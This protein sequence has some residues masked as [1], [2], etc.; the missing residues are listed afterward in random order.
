MNI[1][2]FSTYA[3]AVLIA[4]IAAFSFFAAMTV[5]EVFAGQPAVIQKAQASV[6]L[7]TPKNAAFWS[8]FD[9]WFTEHEIFR[10]Q[11]EGEL[12]RF[13]DRLIADINANHLKL[14]QAYRDGNLDFVFSYYSK[15][16]GY[17]VPS[18]LSAGCP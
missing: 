9:I 4:A 13:C 1:G 12:G 7:P 14:G 3:R 18:W 5:R 6:E 11:H 17:L 15:F 2:N 10:H 16:A 8:K